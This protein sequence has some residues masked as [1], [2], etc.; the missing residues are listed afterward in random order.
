MRKHFYS[1]LNIFPL[2]FLILY[3]F[4]QHKWSKL[5][6]AI[7]AFYRNFPS[8][9]L[10]KKFLAPHES[11]HSSL[12][13]RDKKDSGGVVKS[14]FFYPRSKLFTLSAQ[15]YEGSRYPWC[16]LVQPPGWSQ[17]PGDQLPEKRP[18]LSLP[19]YAFDFCSYLSGQ[20]LSSHREASLWA[21]R[22]KG[23]SKEV[24]LGYMTNTFLILPIAS[25]SYLLH[26]TDPW[27]PPK[28]CPPFLSPG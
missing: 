19:L 21:W 25:F 2:Y 28:S 11:A 15:D 17:L 26:L 13:W 7:L 10:F 8:N 9:S 12:H 16:H 6:V 23:I 1:S 24:A 14:S 3:F 22:E 4:L 5:K 18:S 20:T 27:L